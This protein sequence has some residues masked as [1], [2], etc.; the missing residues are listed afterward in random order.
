VVPC[1]RERPNFLRAWDRYRDPG[2]VIVGI[3]EQDSPARARDYV[4]QFGGSW[5][6]VVDHGGDVA[7]AYDVFGLPETF[8]LSRTGHISS[9]QVGYASYAVL[10]RNVERLLQDGGSP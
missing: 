7:R 4:R 9:V 1:H 10:A 5:P 3:L 6:N 2:L 8:F